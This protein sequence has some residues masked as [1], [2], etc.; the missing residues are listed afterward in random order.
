MAFS[1]QGNYIVEDGFKEVPDG[2]KKWSKIIK[3]QISNVQATQEKPSVE[4]EMAW[5]N[6]SEFL[7]S[8]DMYITNPNDPPSTC[9]D[10]YV[11]YTKGPL[12]QS[13]W[14]QSDGYNDAL[15]YIFCNGWNTHVLAGCNA[16]AMGQVMKY[17]QY[18]SNY[19][20]NAMP[21]TE[22]TATT[23]NFILSIHNAIAGNYPGNPSYSCEEGTGVSVN[24]DMGVVLKNNFSYSSADWSSYNVNTV[25]NNLDSNRPVIL[26]GSGDDDGHMWVCDGYI[27]ITQYFEDCYVVV[28]KPSYL[29]MNWGWRGDHD[30]WYYYSD[31]SPGQLSFN[32]D[33]KMI[34]NIIP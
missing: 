15:P 22:A 28:F 30:G 34:Y 29:H 20:W 10:H 31:F 24:A 23:A 3:E 2:V 19:N 5:T 17:Y 18:P 26:S 8:Q 1:E 9:Y 27:Q 14:D 13:K 33:T 16:I 21:L 12:T 11:T 7:I 4:I 25:K 32:N 6:V